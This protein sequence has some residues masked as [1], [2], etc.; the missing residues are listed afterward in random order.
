M[1]NY[2]I[3]SGISINNQNSLAYFNRSDNVSDTGVI[4][5]NNLHI[6]YHKTLFDSTDAN[7]YNPGD[8]ISNN[9]ARSITLNWTPQSIREF[10]Y[11]ILKNTFD[12]GYPIVNTYNLCDQK[13]AIVYNLG[14]YNHTSRNENVDT[15]Y[16]RNH[17]ISL[18][19]N[20]TNNPFLCNNC[21]GVVCASGFTF[22]PVTCACAPNPVCLPSDGSDT[23]CV[24][25]IDVTSYKTTL[26][27]YL[28]K[29]QAA[30]NQLNDNISQ[31][32]NS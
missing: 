23:T 32:K 1:S 9:N 15:A 20:N 18:I 19:E 7:T 28:Q 5:N 13:L 25:N 30:I 10:K 4:A 12:V 14:G 31:I 29:Y 17:T 3:N 8:P 6:R 24:E 11:N 27:G 2:I 26:Q 16:P 22:D 21:Q